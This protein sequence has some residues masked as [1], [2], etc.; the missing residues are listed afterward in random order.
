MD[1]AQMPQYK[2]TALISLCVFSCSF[3][4]ANDNIYTFTV[5]KCL[6]WGWLLDCVQ[7]LYTFTFQ[8]PW[9]FPLGILYLFFPH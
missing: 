2:Q 1:D 4:S 9:P 6:C 8:S 5:I 7:V 3:Y